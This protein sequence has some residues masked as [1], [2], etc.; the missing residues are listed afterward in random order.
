MN[1][2]PEPVVAPLD[3]VRRATGVAAGAGARS[4]PAA[5]PMDGSWAT[6][7]VSVAAW[8]CG[9]GSAGPKAVISGTRAA[10]AGPPERRTA[11]E[12]E[13]CTSKVPPSVR[14]SSQRTVDAL[15][16]RCSHTRS[17]SNRSRWAQN[18]LSS[19]DRHSR[20]T[21]GVDKEL[22]RHFQ[23]L[24]SRIP[25]HGSGATAL[26]RSEREETDARR[27]G[28]HRR[29]TCLPRSRG[30]RLREVGSAR[31]D[32]MGAPAGGG[33]ALRRGEE[34]P[35]GNGPRARRLHAGPPDL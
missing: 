30:G 19:S 20:P 15:T 29:R 2:P 23:A 33:P 28:T 21:R 14:H 31:A 5:V 22:D 1:E 12:R 17:A 26:R 16:S 24:L 3:A 7:P 11:L 27:K 6:D 13:L 18:C 10:A 35:I 25:D 34:P 4:A 9:P 8:A 32:P